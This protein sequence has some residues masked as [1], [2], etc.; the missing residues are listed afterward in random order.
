MEEK[1]K[2]GKR[3][4]LYTPD[5]PA[6]IGPYAQGIEQRHLLFFSGQIP[7]D[8]QTGKLTGDDFASQTK[9]VLRNM[10]A[11]LS[12]QGLTAANVIKT[13]VYLTDMSKFAEVNAEYGKYFAANPPARSCVGV[14][15]LPM[16]ALVEIEMIAAR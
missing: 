11:L 4:V 1:C 3:T 7:I 6:A 16:G 13:T 5:A 12:A 2:C 9:Q 15:A 8:P 14:T 10:D